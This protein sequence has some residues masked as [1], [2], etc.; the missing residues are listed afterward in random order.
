M[1]VSVPTARIEQE[2]NSSRRCI[3]VTGASSFIGRHLA[4]A[5]SGRNDVDLRLM[6]HVRPLGDAIPKNAAVFTGDLLRPESLDGFLEPG[7]T[8]IN[9]V[10]LVS[11]SE[12]DSPDAVANL[13]MACR[14]GRVKRLVHCST[15]VV[16]G[17]A[18]DDDITEETQCRPTTGYEISKYATESALRG[19]AAGHFELAVLRPTAVFGKDGKNLLKLSGELSGGSR[20]SSYAK[21]CLYGRR[22]MNLVFIDNAVAALLFLADSEREMKGEVFIIS[23][24]DDPM[25]NYRD[26]EK[27]LM[28]RLGCRDYRFPRFRAPETVLKILLGLAGRSNSNT[29]RNYNSG[30]IFRAGFRKPVSFREGLESFAAW[31]RQCRR[32][33][34]PDT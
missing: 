20:L 4:A 3:A 18:P 29:G 19:L 27:F 21:S 33:A 10:N 26:V 6:A 22:R 9:L 34:G 24:D 12:K 7:C 1:G 31:Y 11:P 17:S 28:E 25:N 8:V 30:K 16:A 32:P 15:A 5:L 13:A 14:A 23:D 2:M